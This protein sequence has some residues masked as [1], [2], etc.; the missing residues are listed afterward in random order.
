MT[1]LKSSKEKKETV[2]PLKY[3]CEFCKREFARETTLFSHICEYKHRWLERDKQGN[4][5]AFQ[6]WMQFY[7]KT[8]MSKTKNKTYEEFIR[9]PYYGAFARFGS[10]CVDVNAI[11]VSRYIDWLL[12]DN[13]KI[14][15]WNSDTVYSRFLCEYLR[16]EDPYDAVHRG[17]EKSFEM[18]ED[19][20]I[21]AHDIFRFGN[22]NK[23]CYAITTGKISPWMLYQSNSGTQFLDTLN[24]DHVRIIIDYINPEQWALKFKR[25]PEIAKQIKDLLNAGGY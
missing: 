2:K 6:A 19:A 7:A 15:T 21:L 12:R 17:V 18:G 22:Q 8:S 4:R 16:T 20:G 14:D 25:E 9:S 3:G 24:P 11:N 13:I 23:I 5:L 10:Y 1:T